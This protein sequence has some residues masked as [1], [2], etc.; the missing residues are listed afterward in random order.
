VTAKVFDG[1]W[2]RLEQGQRG[3]FY[4]FSSP[5]TN[6]NLPVDASRQLN[7]SLLLKELA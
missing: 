5:V 6:L 2:W 7:K 4:T 3:R 1:A